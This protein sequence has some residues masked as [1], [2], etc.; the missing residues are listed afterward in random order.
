VKPTYPRSAPVDW[1]PYL[2]AGAVRTPRLPRFHTAL[3]NCAHPRGAAP[4]PLSPAVSPS[5]LSLP[6]RGSRPA[7]L[8]SSL[9]SPTRAPELGA[10]PRRSRSL[11]PSL[12]RT[13]WPITRPAPQ[14]LP[15]AG[16]W[17]S[18]L[19]SWH[20]VPPPKPL[21]SPVA[22]LANHSPVSF[23]PPSS[24]LSGG[25]RPPSSYSF[26]ADHIRRAYRLPLSGPAHWPNQLTRLGIEAV[27]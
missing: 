11:F 6:V 23:R 17:R 16:P 20:S 4:S 8:R 14:G 19:R 2:R 21:A 26:P 9:R 1:A 27:V 22:T 24:A 5:P 15:Q 25:S 3:A 10:P 13:L 12:R 7:L 18:L